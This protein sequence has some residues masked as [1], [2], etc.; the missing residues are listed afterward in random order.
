[1]SWG[2][3][4]K[5]DLFI[6]NIIV[7]TKEEADYRLE[8]VISDNQDIVSKIKMMVAARPTDLV[9][10]SEGDDVIDTLSYKVDELLEEYRDNQRLIF[11]LNAFKQSLD[12]VEEKN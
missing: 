1:M 3:D 7:K 11:L 2:T 9:D 12:D 10:K 5:A 4:F 8:D 6:R